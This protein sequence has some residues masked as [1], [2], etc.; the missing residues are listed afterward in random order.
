MKKLLFVLALGTFA[1]CNSG[2]SS[3]TKADST[4]SAIDSTANVKTDSVEHKA[5]SLVNKI[6]STADAKTDSLKK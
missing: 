6:D 1:A 5:D 2:T 4:A 3:E